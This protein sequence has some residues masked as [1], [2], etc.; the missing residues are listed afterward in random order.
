MN[1]IVTI[2]LTIAL[3]LLNLAQA[4]SLVQSY[5]LDELTLEKINQQIAGKEIPG[6]LNSLLKDQRINIYLKDETQE[7]TLN[8]VTDKKT[9]KSLSL[10]ET[11]DPT[12][13]V[14]TSQAA[15]TEIIN[16]PDAKSALLQALKE[17]KIS[18]TA[19]GF[20][21]KLRF[22]FASVAARIG[23]VFSKSEEAV[24]EK[25]DKGKDE[26][27]T[28]TTTVPPEAQSNKAATEKPIEEKEKKEEKQTE[29][30]PAE[31]P[32]E[33]NT[34]NLPQMP[35][36]YTI[37]LA[38][39]GFKPAELVIKK[40]DTIEWKVSRSGQLHLGMILGTQD[41]SKIKSAILKDGETYSYTFD[42]AQ[43]CTIVD[44][45]TTTQVGTVVVE[46]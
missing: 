33:N 7:V 39:T 22:S 28:I 10:G 12:L 37:E 25:P 26:T 32:A 30:L 35:Q 20:W 21:N 44:G 13:K 41:C 34:P 19:V 27:T 45:I 6:A 40:G 31:I 16:S 3:M 17:G 24:T 2:S 46:E 38:A 9:F 18:Y 42:Q 43:K 29:T 14:Y 11:S 23:S 1:K 8:L 5:Q 36:K 4:E 15:I